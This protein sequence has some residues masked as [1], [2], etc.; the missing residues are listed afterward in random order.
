MK[1]YAYSYLT[2]ENEFYFHRL[3]FIHAQK[4][5]IVKYS[6][7]YMH[8][9]CLSS[10]RPKGMGNYSEA[11]EAS[12]VMDLFTQQVACGSVSCFV[13][14]INKQFEIER[15]LMRYL[16]KI[17]SIRQVYYSPEN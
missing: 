9:P 11:T 14:R 7:V 12:V 5:G 10:Y 17:V 8:D 1:H 2:S 15:L 16:I 6:K 3:G 13:S 4:I